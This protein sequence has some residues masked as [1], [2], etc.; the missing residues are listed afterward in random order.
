NIC[1]EPWERRGD[2]IPTL[3]FGKS[4]TSA[5]GAKLTLYDLGGSE[6][7]RG[8]WHRYYHSCHCIIY[9][10][11]ASDQSCM[12][13]T[14]AALRET[15][16]HA[17]TQGKPVLVVSNKHDIPGASS[18]VEMVSTLHAQGTFRLVETSALHTLH[19][20]AKGKAMPIDAAMAQTLS[21]N[22]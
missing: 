1:L 8:Y 19:T 21:T 20:G 13:D 16:Q 18:P 11:D 3:G 12:D 2:T 9:V 4:E 10:V 14:T 15:M 22:L 7:I 6:S 17:M 5:G